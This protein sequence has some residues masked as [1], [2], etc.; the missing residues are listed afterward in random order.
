MKV[1]W[2]FVASCGPDPK[3][4]NVK[5]HNMENAT[6]VRSINVTN[7]ATDVGFISN[8]L[9]AAASTSMGEHIFW[10][11]NQL[12]DGKKETAKI[13]NRKIQSE[14]PKDYPSAMPIIAIVGSDIL[15]TEGRKLVKR[16]F[17]P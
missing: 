3:G 15:V 17:W 10:N 9:V 11:W 5:I 1:K 8:V 13:E 12:L 14:I 4:Q 7:W 16:S 2:P 6:H